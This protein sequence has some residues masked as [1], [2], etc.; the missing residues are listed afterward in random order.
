M[1]GHERSTVGVYFRSSRD[2]EI[3]PVWRGPS[4]IQ[5]P[6]W[7][8]SKAIPKRPQVPCT[9]RRCFAIFLRNWR[10]VWGIA[11]NSWARFG[12]SG[13]GRAR[14][15]QGPHALYR[16]KYKIFPRS[17]GHKAEEI[18]R[19]TGSVFALLFRR[20]SSMRRGSFCDWLV[21]PRRCGKV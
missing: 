2:W 19:V 20:R 14:L 13:A 4:T 1:I 17:W 15:S 12:K 21:R 3:G 16:E 10:T 8:G 7:P 11:G 5:G 9:I 18:A 6:T